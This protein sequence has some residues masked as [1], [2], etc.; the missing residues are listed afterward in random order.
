MAI[1][2]SLLIPPSISIKPCLKCSH[3]G[4]SIVWK[5][6]ASRVLVRC[7]VVKRDDSFYMRRSVELARSALGYTS[8]NPMVGCVIVQNGEIVGEGFHPK[9]GEPH[10]EV[11]FSPILLLSSLS[12]FFLPIFHCSMK[13]F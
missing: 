4:K 5:S 2:S 8:P 11:I 10:A 12:F 7:E 1:Y 13:G 9:A 3:R 6:P